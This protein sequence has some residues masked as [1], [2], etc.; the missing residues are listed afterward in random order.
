MP[1]KFRLQKLL[2]YR[3][4]QKKQAQEELARRQRK[5]HAVQQELMRLQGEEQRLL[6][7]YQLSQGQG[8]EL[9]IFALVSMEHYRCYLQKCY[10]E[11]AEELQQAEK[12][13]EEQRGVVME[14]WRGCKVL[15]VLRDKAQHHYLEEEKISEQRLNDELGLN[16]FMRQR[17]Q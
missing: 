14:S 13:L 16:C 4:N 17:K 11:Q 8:H 5:V 10:R 2:E 7:N 3:E 1:F 15:S 9:D 12:K 6:E